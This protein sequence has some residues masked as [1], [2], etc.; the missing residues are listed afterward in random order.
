MFIRRFKI[1][2]LESI[3]KIAI[4]LHPKWF[5]KNALINIPIDTLINKTLIAVNENKLVGFAVF[6][7]QE[8]ETKI[9]WLGINPKFH[10]K[11]IGKQ[12]LE[13]IIKHVE[14]IGTKRII[15]ETVVEQNPKDLSYDETLKFYLA[16]GFKL[17]KKYP[18]EHFQNYTF[19]KG[20][21][22]KNI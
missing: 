7:S 21:L 17:R 8:G 19:S 22:E 12:L 15:V 20:I 2:D 18:K 16:Q 11:G 4:S 14:K 5:D 3:K 6:S 10:R 13:K 1:T 9:N